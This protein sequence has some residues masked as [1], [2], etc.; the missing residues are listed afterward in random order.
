MKRLLI[1]FTG[2]LLLMCSAVSCRFAKEEPLGDTV[3]AQVFEPVVAAKK[4]VVPCD[5]VAAVA[6]DSVDIFYYLKT[7]IIQRLP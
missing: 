3:A 5:S 4:K 7:N 6:H 2:F 1:G